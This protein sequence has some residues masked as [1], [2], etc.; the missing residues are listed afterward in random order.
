MVLAI[1]STS[2]L[3]TKVLLLIKMV[4]TG[5]IVPVWSLD[6]CF[7][8]FKRL[9]TQLYYSLYLIKLAGMSLEVWK[10]V[11]KSLKK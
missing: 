10:I 6:F 5:M 3:V 2:K 4:N 11:M 7:E 8:I 1:F 9:I